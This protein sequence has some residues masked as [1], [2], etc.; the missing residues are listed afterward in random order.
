MMI[1]STEDEYSLSRAL[2][3]YGVLAW[4]QSAQTS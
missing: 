1:P 2:S 3:R 4:I